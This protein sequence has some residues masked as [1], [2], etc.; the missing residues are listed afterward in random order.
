HTEGRRTSEHITNLL[1]GMKDERSTWDFV[2]SFGDD[3][4]Q[5]YWKRKVAWP[6]QGELA[7]VEFAV[8]KYLSAGRATS[9]LQVLHYVLRDI[10]A[11]T[12]FRMLDAGIQELN[13]SEAAPTSHFVYEL[14]E[15]FDELQRRAD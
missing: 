1:F 15:V 11:G 7:D 6:L 2:A 5:L 4:E 12:I 9:A 14:G 8:E 13:A 10:P 3:I